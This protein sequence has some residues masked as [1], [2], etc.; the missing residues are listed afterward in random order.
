[1]LVI[2]NDANVFLSLVE[3]HWSSLKIFILKH[4]FLLLIV[5]L[6]FGDLK[7]AVHRCKPNSISFLFGEL[8]LV[9]Y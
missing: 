5:V 6:A 7:D 2:L 8:L 1:M 9:F 3:K 4:I